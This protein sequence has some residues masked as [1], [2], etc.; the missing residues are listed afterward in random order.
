MLETVPVAAWPERWWGLGKASG[1]CP[2]LKLFPEHLA[3]GRIRPE[4]AVLVW[5][6]RPQPAG[7][8]GCTNVAV[9]YLPRGC[10]TGLPRDD[11]ARTRWRL[12]Y[13]QWDE[14]HGAPAPGWMKSE[15][16]TPEG[17]IAG[18]IARR[19]LGGG[20][21]DR[22]LDMMSARVVGFSRERTLQLAASRTEQGLGVTA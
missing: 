14:C 1:T 20:E 5:D 18:W 7:E 11:M 15:D 21:L 22:V 2:T 17:S 16:E 8:L 3:G 10:L 6:M 13:S 9:G 12:W 4:Y 19:A